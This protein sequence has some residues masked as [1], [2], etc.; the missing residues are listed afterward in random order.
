MLEDD[1]PEVSSGLNEFH[2]LTYLKR[3][4]LAIK[5]QENETDDNI[6]LFLN[7]EADNIVNFIEAI[8]SRSIAWGFVTL[9]GEVRFDFCVVY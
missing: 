8:E 9:G 6:A 5:H 3:W 7:G 2:W 1:E 4:F